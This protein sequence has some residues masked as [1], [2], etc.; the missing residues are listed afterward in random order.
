MP[1]GWSP[2]RDGRYDHSEDSY[3]D[4]DVSADVV[5]ETAA[6]TL[7]KHRPDHGET[8]SSTQR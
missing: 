2:R 4:R 8:R 5:A 1:A 3:D 6:R 7:N